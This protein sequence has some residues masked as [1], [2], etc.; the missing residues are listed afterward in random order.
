V[1]GPAERHHATARAAGIAELAILTYTREQ[2]AYRF[3]HPAGPHGQA[4]AAVQRLR[5]ERHSGVELIDPDRPLL[6]PVA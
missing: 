5:A 1:A 3:R 6:P 4:G 2:Y